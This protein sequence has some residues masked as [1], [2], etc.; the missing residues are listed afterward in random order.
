[1][2]LSWIERHPWMLNTLLWLLT[3]MTLGATL[4]PQEQIQQHDL[5]Q[6]DKAGHFLIFGVWTFLLGLALHLKGQRPLPYLA[7]FLAGSLFGLTIE[8]LQETL[9]VNRTMSLADWIAD[10]FG[11]L[12]AVLLLRRWLGKKRDNFRQ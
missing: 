2:M 11:S 1:M 9:P 10:S 7:I 12:V 8:V 3:A 5:F 6:Y 4:V